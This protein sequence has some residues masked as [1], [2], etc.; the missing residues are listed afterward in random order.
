MR[1]PAI[2]IGLDQLTQELSNLGIKDAEKE[3]KNIAVRTKN[4]RFLNRISV[5]LNKRQ[6][7]ELERAKNS[8]NYHVNEFLGVLQQIR[9]KRK[10]K[11]ITPIRPGDS[12]YKILKEVTQ[13]AVDFCDA[14]Q[15]MAIAGFRI[16]IELGLEFM[17]R[18]YGLNKFKYYH[19]KIVDEY[20]NAVELDASPYKEEGKEYLQ[21]YLKKMREEVGIV[22]EDTSVFNLLDFIR[23]YEDAKSYGA[24]KEHWLKAQ[25]EAFAQFDSVPEPYHLYGD[26]AIDRYKKYLINYSKKNK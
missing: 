6:Q 21:Y 4:N 26:K 8:S 17:G 25:F 24:K 20:K 10:H 16:Y 5:K 12:Q 15:L 14:Y 1:Q 23:A 13:L 11:G 7:Q 18:N 3:A 9:L 22:I 19:S 2:H